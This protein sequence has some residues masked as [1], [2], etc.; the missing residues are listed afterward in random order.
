[1]RFIAIVLAAAVVVAP[2]SPPPA[3][4]VPYTQTFYGTQRSDPYHWM[5]AGDP[6][7]RRSSRRRAIIRSSFSRRIPEGR[8]WSRS[9][10]CIRSILASH[11]DFSRRSNWT[12]GVLSPKFARQQR[13]VVTSAGR[14]SSSA[15]H[16]RCNVSAERSRYLVV[17]AISPRHQNRIW[18]D[19]LKRRRRYPR[20]RC[21]RIPRSRAS[22]RSFRRSG[23]NVAR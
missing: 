8:A 23:R 19:V 16:H 10:R 21:R 18:G 4:T 5:E 3:A 22:D 20:L 7:L 9:P 11:D 2:S 6:S 14:W 17:R 1:M 13:S 12:E 15:G